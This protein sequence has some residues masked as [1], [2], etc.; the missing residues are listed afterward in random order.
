ML[1]N[2]SISKYKKQKLN[3]LSTA[4][5]HSKLIFILSKSLISSSKNITR[6][7]SYNN[8]MVFEKNLH[9]FIAHSSSKRFR[10]VLFSLS[11]KLIKQNF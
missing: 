3:C 11:T 8:R 10:R 4:V 9:I 2:F 7:K 1:S 5:S 6:N